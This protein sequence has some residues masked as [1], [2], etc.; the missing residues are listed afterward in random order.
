M[1]T[2]KVTDLKTEERVALAKERTGQLVDHVIRLFTMHEANAIVLYSPV[3]SDQIPQ[4]YAAHAFNQF[5]SS[6]ACYEVVRLCACWEKP[7]L[8]D[9]SVPTILKLI[10]DENVLKALADEVQSSVSDP[11]IGVA[12]AD[13]CR[14][15]I[16]AA[17]IRAG[18]IERDPRT[19]T[20]RNHR[21]KYLAHNLVKTRAEEGGLKGTMKTGDEAWLLQE[22][23][24]VANEL[25]HGLSRSAFDWQG[26]RNMARRNAEMLWHG[27]KF[28]GLE[29]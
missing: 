29:R 22:T 20:L 16:D 19:A 18:D 21:H 3:L 15:R 25:H 10:Q 12:M 5:Q 4:S 27:C 17:I 28:T 6:M 11:S 1:A 2:K 9:A 26:H 23:Q 13:Q 7:D 24:F 14:K 8:N